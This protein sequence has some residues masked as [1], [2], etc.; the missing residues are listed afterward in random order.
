MVCG[1]PIKSTPQDKQISTGR[2]FELLLWV[3]WEV[4]PSKV[5]QPLLEH[6]VRNH[7]WFPAIDKVW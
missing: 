7:S 4:V 1:W 5:V 2:Y 3:V 6:G